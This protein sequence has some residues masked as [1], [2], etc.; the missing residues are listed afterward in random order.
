ME[1]MELFGET[2]LILMIYYSFIVNKEQKNMA[3]DFFK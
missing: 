3:Q 1:E 2:M